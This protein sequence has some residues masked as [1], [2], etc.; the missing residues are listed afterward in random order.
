LRDIGGSEIATFAEP[1]GHLT[2]EP[3]LERRR[4]DAAVDA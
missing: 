4:Q 3:V 1:Q 2:V